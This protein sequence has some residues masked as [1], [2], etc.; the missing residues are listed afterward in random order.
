MSFGDIGILNR[1]QRQLTP[2]SSFQKKKGKTD[3]VGTSVVVEVCVEVIEKYDKSS[4][5]IQ[6]MLQR[7]I[8]LFQKEESSSDTESSSSFQCHIC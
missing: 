6:R 3:A 1:K 4:Q 5:E 8:F 7:V 2:K